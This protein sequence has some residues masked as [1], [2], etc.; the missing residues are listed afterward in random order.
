[1]CITNAE[2]NGLSYAI[3]LNRIY[4]TITAEVAKI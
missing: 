1:M 3:Y 2:L 4:T